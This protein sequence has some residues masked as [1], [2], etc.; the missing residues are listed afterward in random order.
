MRLA[1]KRHTCSKGMPQL[2]SL[3]RMQYRPKRDE[4]SEQDTHNLHLPFCKH[5]V[6]QRGFSI[7]NNADKVRKEVKSKQKRRTPVHRLLQSQLFDNYINYLHFYSFF[8]RLL[9]LQDGRSATN[10][11]KRPE[12]CRIEFNSKS[13]GPKME[14]RSHYYE[15]YYNSIVYNGDRCDGY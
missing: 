10:S 9:G 2:N 6:T 4:W 12:R 15:C 11:I 13:E 14:A 8:L 7:N 5:E 1:S 3:L